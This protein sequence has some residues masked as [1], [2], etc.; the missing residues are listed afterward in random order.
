VAIAPCAEL[1]QFLH[2]GMI[3]PCVV[4]HRQVYWIEHANIAT[5]ALQ[6]TSTFE[7]Q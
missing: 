7:R 2:F 5:Q 1:T 4:F 6:Y 3:L